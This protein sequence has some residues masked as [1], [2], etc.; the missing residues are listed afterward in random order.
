[1]VLAHYLVN[2]TEGTYY[3][4]DVGEGICDVHSRVG[5]SDQGISGT[6]WVNPNFG[7]V[8]FYLN[9]MYQ[10]PDGQVYLIPGSGLHMSGDIAGQATQTLSETFTVTENSK[11]EESSFEVEVTID[12]AMP[13]ETV[14]ILQMNGQNTQIGKETYSADQLPDGITPNPETAYLI[15]EIQTQTGIQRQLIEPEEDSIS[16]F[17]PLDTQIC[18]QDHITVHW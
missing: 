12:I 11:T 13:A 18:T 6:I 14:T 8:I 5:G 15:V 4:T 9:P 16:V 2:S 3:A 1:M 17:I 10:T 7:D